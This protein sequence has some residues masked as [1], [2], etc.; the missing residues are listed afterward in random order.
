[1]EIKDTGKD[2]TEDVSN[3]EIKDTSK[4]TTEEVSNTYVL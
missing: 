4:D 3:M 2:T 1:M